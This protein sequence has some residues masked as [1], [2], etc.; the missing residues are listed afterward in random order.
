MKLRFYNAKILTMADDKV[1]DGELHTDGGRITYVGTTKTER[2]AFDK[3]ID[4]TGKLIIPGFKD[5]H[6]HTAMTFLRSY[7]DD[8][9][10]NEWLYNQVFPHEAK[11]TEEAIYVFTQLGNMEYLTSGIT[12]SFDMYF[13]LDSYA[14]ANVDMGYRTVLCGSINDFGGTVEGI[15]EEYNKFNNYNELI[16]YRLGFHA[17]YTTKRET[18]EGMAAL[19]QK[20][21]AAMYTHNSETLNEVNGCKERYGITPTQLFDKLG[22]LE[23]GGGGFHCVWFD[24]KDMEIFRDK[25]LWMV[26]NPSSNLKLASGI[27]PICEMRKHG[28]TRFA[29]GT[30]GAASNNCLDMFREMFLVTALQKVKEMDASACPAFDVLEMAT[31][32]GALA[33]GLT[34]CDVLAEGKCADFAVIDLK[35]PNMQP[36]HNIPKNLVYSGSKQNVYMTVVNGKI[37]YENGKFLTVDANEVYAR[38]EKL[39]HEI[40]G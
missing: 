36:V 28:M 35:Q 32:G 19:S 2:G 16:S 5:A 12:S 39:I 31:K 17:E 11:L 34:D 21:K 14:K 23:Y 40:C 33:M 13:K 7:A 1:I 10:L 6:T 20:Y 26:T 18:L 38:A 27:A 29:I 30:D 25:G 15:E 8:L 3:E 22:M 37:L 9:P 4:L 24:E